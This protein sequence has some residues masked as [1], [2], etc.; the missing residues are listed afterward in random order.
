MH[1]YYVQRI[2]PNHYPNFLPAYHTNFFPFGPAYHFQPMVMLPFQ[3]APLQ[4]PMRPINRPF[5]ILSAFTNEKGAFDFVKTAKTVDQM[6]KTVNQVAPLIK[7]MSNMFQ[8][9]AK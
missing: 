4:Q 6:V 1:H 9:T 7:Q 3:G 2:F 8:L 5:N